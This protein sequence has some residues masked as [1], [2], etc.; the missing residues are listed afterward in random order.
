MYQHGSKFTANELIKRITGHGLSIEPYIHYLRENMVNSISSR[1][2]P[3]YKNE[4]SLLIPMS[5]KS[6]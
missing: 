3:L 2:C 4:E 5:S 1:C 6:F